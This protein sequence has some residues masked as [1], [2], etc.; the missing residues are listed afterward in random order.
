[1]EVPEEEMKKGAENGKKHKAQVFQNLVKNTKYYYGLDT[2][3][4]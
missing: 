1:V 3:C 4:P 2:N